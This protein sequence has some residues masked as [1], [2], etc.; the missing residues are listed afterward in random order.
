MDSAS[1]LPIP[2][3]TSRLLKS[4]PPMITIAVDGFRVTFLKY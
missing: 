2:S 1:M 3:H 4:L